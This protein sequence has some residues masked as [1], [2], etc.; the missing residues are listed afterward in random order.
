MQASSPQKKDDLISSSYQRLPTMLPVKKRTAS[1]GSSSTSKRAKTQAKA[2]P[3]PLPSSE[4]DS[5]LELDG[6]G[7]EDSD[8]G[9]DGGEEEDED[10]EVNEFELEGSDD[11][12]EDDL[13]GDDGEDLMARVGD[14]D[15][16]DD[17]DDDDDEDDEVV[18]VVSPAPLKKANVRNSRAA[19]PLKP[20]ELRALAFAELTASP[21]STLIA[22]Q[23]SM[24]LTPVAPPTPATSPLQPLLKSLHAHITT[25]PSVKASSLA[26]L[27]KKGAMVPPVKGL[28][29][30]W[31]KVDLEWEKPRAEDVRVVGRWAWGGSL[32]VKGEYVVDMA[33]AM[34]SVS[35]IVLS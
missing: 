1:G 3:P 16:D 32:R 28:D 13:I 19:A 34:P 31:G 11:G 7:D 27:A 15:E 23:V 14:D 9:R 8:D 24:L 6:E 17:D 18:P 4:E 22:T 20:A 26:R 21:I 10:S 25:L 12:S 29:G 2:A 5:D 35:T 30:K 33:I